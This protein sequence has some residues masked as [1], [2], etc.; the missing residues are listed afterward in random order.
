MHNQEDKMHWSPDGRW[1]YALSNRDGFQCIWAFPLDEQTKRPAGPPVAAIHSHGARLS[2]R[3]ANLVP[4]DFSV[5]RDKIVF[6]Q[7]EI[8]GNIWMTEIR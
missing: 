2:I 5:A 8:T 3:N 4:Q 7:G 6:N 1:I